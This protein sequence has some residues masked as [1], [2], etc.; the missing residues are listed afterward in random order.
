MAKEFN[1]FTET[2]FDSIKSSFR[3]FLES[4]EKFKDYNFDGSA[5][6]IFLDVLAFHTQY[7][8]FYGN[9]LASEKWLSLAQRRQSVVENAKNL[10]YVPRSRRS[11]SAKISFQLFPDG[12]F[13]GGTLSIPKGT[14]FTTKVDDVSYTFRTPNEVFVSPDG[15][16]EYH[17]SELEIL[18]GKI[19]NYSYELKQN[20]NSV[21]IPNA[22]VDTSRL[23]V[24]VRQSSADMTGVEFK[25]ADN[26]TQIEENENVFFLQEVE[27]EKFEI[28]FGDGIIG[29]SVSTGNVI[30]IEYAVSNG[31]AS[32]GATAFSLSGSIPDVS[33]VSTVIVDE[34]SFGGIE[35][36]GIESIRKRAPQFYERQYRAVTRTDYKDVIED[37][38]PASKDVTAWGGEDNIPPRFGAVFISVVPEQGFVISETQRRDIEN[39][40]VANYAVLGIKPY[41]VNPEYLF[42]VPTINV[43]Y[44]SNV[45][46]T[47]A[48]G[49]KSA[50]Q[51]TIGTFNDE[52]LGGFQNNFHYSKF[53]AAI[54]DANNAIVSNDTDIEIYIQARSL[55][56]LVD[57]GGVTFFEK[58]LPGSIHTN[59]FIYSTFNELFLEDDSNGVIS[60]FF[61]NTSGTKVKV[62]DSV[63]TVDYDTGN[64]NIDFDSFDIDQLQLD[65]N[66]SIKF[67]ATPETFDV[68]PVRNQVIAIDETETNVSVTD[69]I[70][71]II[72]E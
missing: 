21:V 41:V 52:N 39:A 46:N 66:E 11:S 9:M 33:S 31:S 12:G 28:Y 60:A 2:D 43:N 17:V 23:T 13:G 48:A 5:L 15:S 10:G 63:A 35:I 69:T 37:V 4:Q 27:G 65:P 50:V 8:A 71:G 42:V 49:I 30:D 67:Y 56:E 7:N 36:E 24:I 57:Q 40:L 58:L 54:D 18:E 55:N 45:H 22:G 29:S 62:I 51:D 14:T 61:I 1:K 59:R 72:I 47:T 68:D 19:L 3:S 16:S 70:T 38:Y 6:S 53:V 20:E 44:N 32:N 34:K 64:I 26:I 25:L